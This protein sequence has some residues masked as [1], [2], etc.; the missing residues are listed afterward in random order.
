M[1]ISN[2]AE[3]QFRELVPNHDGTLRRGTEPGTVYLWD[4]ERKHVFFL[5]PMPHPG[6]RLRSPSDRTWRPLSEFVR[7]AGEA[8]DKA[9]FDDALD[10][11][12]PLLGDDEKYYTTNAQA[13]I[14][15]ALDQQEAKDL[16]DEWNRRYRCKLCREA[17]ARDEMRDHLKSHPPAAE[18]AL[19]D[20]EKFFEDV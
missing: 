2:D 9:G 5:E 20:P 15:E 4:G 14:T 1:Q 10:G 6:L 13:E 12:Y 11:L 16:F 8:L 19:D 3:K 18:S 7:M 17:I